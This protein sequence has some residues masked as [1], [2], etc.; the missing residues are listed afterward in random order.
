MRARYLTA[1]TLYCTLN[2]VFGLFWGYGDTTKLS[3]VHSLQ[4]MPIGYC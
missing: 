1:D 2:I 4:P 3:I